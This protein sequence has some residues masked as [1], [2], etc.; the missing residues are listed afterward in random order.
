MRAVRLHGA[1]SRTPP[2]WLPA[3]R[4]RYRRPVRS[5]GS[6]SSH[7]CAAPVERVRATTAP[8]FSTRLV[9]SLGSGPILVLDLRLGLRP[10]LRFSTRLVPSLGSG[11]ILVLD[12][13][14]GLRPRLRFS[15]RLVPSLGSGPILV[16]DLRLGLRP[17]LRFSAA[18]R[19][20]GPCRE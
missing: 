13:R 8:L 4:G 7:G 11:P 17:R 16:L 18:A 9:P 15:T 14:L 3:V 12:L 10:R 20:S 19:E 5:R 6:A 2:R 1:W